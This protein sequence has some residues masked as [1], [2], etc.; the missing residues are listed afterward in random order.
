MRRELP[1]ISQ[2][3]WQERVGAFRAWEGGSRYL[4]LFHFPNS[5]L[6]SSLGCLAFH[7]WKMGLLIWLLL[8]AVTGHC[9][10]VMLGSLRQYLLAQKADLIPVTLVP[11][12]WYESHDMRTR[13]RDRLC[14]GQ[15]ILAALAGDCVRAV[16][17]QSYLLADRR[18]RWTWSQHRQVK[19]EPQVALVRSQ[20]PL[21]TICP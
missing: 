11:M 17:S 20:V 21:N 15:G 4:S 18:G 9:H 10:L 7:W 19:M 12:R 13:G 3:R 2:S 14:L 1:L 8:T 16:Y 5:C 6:H